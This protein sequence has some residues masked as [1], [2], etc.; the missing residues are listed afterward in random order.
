M[1]SI[2]VLLNLSHEPRAYRSAA[3][4]ANA[5]RA[6]FSISPIRPKSAAW[7]ELF[8]HAS[9]TSHRVDGAWAS[10]LNSETLLTGCVV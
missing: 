7:G 5:S 8:R 4:F 9:A 1:R 2:S 6:A 10:Y 3:S